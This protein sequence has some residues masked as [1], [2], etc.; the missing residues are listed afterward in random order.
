MHDE[1]WLRRWQ[2]NQIGFHDAEV[3]SHLTRYISNFDLNPGSTLFLPLCGKS[4]DIGW[5]AQQGFQVTGVELSEIAIRAFFTEQKLQ[6]QQLKLERF[7][8]RRSDNICLLEGDFFD[9]QRENLDNCS[10]VY[11][12]AALIALDQSNRQRYVDWMHSIIGENADMLLITLGYDQT[13]MNGPPFS[14]PQTE[15]E[16]H[17][18][19]A[20]NIDILEQTEIVDD[21]PRWR[22]K[23]LSSLIETVYQ[24]RR[25]R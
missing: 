10:L 6:F 15:V 21:S 13:E 25:K 19:Q 24:L 8:M 7:I 12:R 16:L 3:N 9:L 23:G 18:G 1:D 20:F 14:V 2:K 4:A 22:D 11:D 17:Y 5:L